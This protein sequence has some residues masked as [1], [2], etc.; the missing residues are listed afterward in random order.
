[1][2]TILRAMI[3]PFLISTL[4]LFSLLGVVFVIGRMIG[5]DA[6]PPVQVL[7]AATDVTWLIQ[8]RAAVH[9]TVTVTLVLMGMVLLASA[10]VQRF[11]Y[12]RR[13]LG[14]T[15]VGYMLLTTAAWNMTVVGLIVYGGPWHLMS[16]IIGFIEAVMVTTA[17]LIICRAELLKRSVR[18]ENREQQIR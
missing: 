2:N 3:K 4:F 9:S 18:G 10:K 15:A 14:M 16:F 5:Y 12:G 7:Y 17:V 1:M 13:T 6:V 11:T 8:A